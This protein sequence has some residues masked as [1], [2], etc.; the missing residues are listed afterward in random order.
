MT[1]LIVTI[2][3][4]AVH[5]IGAHPD[6]TWCKKVDADPP[7][8][9][10]VNW[11]S[12]R[13]MLPAVAPLARIMRYGYQSQWFGEETI[14]LKAS[15]VAQRLLLS[16]QRERKVCGRL[17]SAPVTTADSAIGVSLPTTDLHCA[18]LWRDW[19]F[20]R[21]VWPPWWEQELGQH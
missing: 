7:Q 6:E 10:Y 16:L 11:L 1:A 18:L 12:D 19:W 3:I 5:G 4:V 2:S 8:E 13:Q 17:P 14:G 15:T 20:L 21:W 9:R